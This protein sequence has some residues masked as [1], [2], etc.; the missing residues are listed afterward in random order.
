MTYLK[1]RRKWIWLQVEHSQ[2]SKLSFWM[3]IVVIACK[4]SYLFF[5]SWDKSTNDP[6]SHNEYNPRHQTGP[7]SAPNGDGNKQMGRNACGQPTSITLSTPILLVNCLYWYTLYVSKCNKCHLGM[8]IIMGNSSQVLNGPTVQNQ[9]RYR[10][11]T[12][13]NNVSC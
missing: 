13:D 7:S 6:V 8:I 1:L 4:N 10:G 9:H 5:S 12:L 11:L 2:L 3:K